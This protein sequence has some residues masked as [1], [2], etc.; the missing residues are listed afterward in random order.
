MRKSIRSFQTFPCCALRMSPTQCPITSRRLPMCRSMSSQSS[1]SGNRFKGAFNGI[2]PSWKSN[3]E[4]GKWKVDSR[5][6]AIC[7]SLS[8]PHKPVLM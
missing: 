7:L 5:V 4:N 8:I 3:R 6:Q 1:P 2:E